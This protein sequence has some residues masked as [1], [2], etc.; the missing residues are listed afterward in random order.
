MMV[1]TI[2]QGRDGA[3]WVT[4]AATDR[5]LALCVRQ[6]RRERTLPP[7]PEEWGAADAALCQSVFERIAFHGIALLL[8]QHTKALAAWPALLRDKMQAEARAQSFWEIGH[9][10]ALAQLIEAL[11]AV[12]ITGAVTKGSA[13][14]YTLYAEPALRR[15][16]DSD[17][18]L[19]GADRRAVGAALAAIGMA[20]TGDARPLQESWAAKCAMGFT[21]VFDLHWRGNASAVISH[22]YDRAGIGQR[23]VP[24]PRLSPAARAIALTDNAILIAINRAMHL[25]FGYVSGSDKTYEQ[26]R[27]IWAVDLDL[28]SAS[29]GDGDWEALGEAAEASGAAPLVL[30][31]L[32]FAHAALDTPIPSAVRARLAA[33]S[34]DPRLLRYLG[35]LRGIERLQLDLSA[36]PTLADKLRLVRYTLLPGTEVL[37]ERFPTATHWPIPALQARRLMSGAGK[38]FLGRG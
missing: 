22:C 35:A 33:H 23:T 3:Q 17:V 2:R 20:R 38:L 10:G 28:F 12:G 11:A 29:F 30:S 1:P 19:P 9:R 4:I 26:D 7:W 5:F 25:Q 16:G 36:S 8:V 14:A 6:S 21:H 15:R 24:M 13:M 32:E 18:L 37:H 31:A 27:L 34:G